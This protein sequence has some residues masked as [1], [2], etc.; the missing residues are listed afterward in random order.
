MKTLDRMDT[1]RQSRFVL[2]SMERGWRRV[3]ALA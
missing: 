1:R 3:S 2:V